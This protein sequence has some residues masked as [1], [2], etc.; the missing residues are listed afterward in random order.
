MAL[1]A[2]MPL[3][4]GKYKPL[5]SNIAYTSIIWK[6][7]IENPLSKFAPFFP[8]KNQPKIC[9]KNP[10]NIRISS[11]GVRDS[12]CAGQETLESSKWTIYAKSSCSSGCLIQLNLN[13]CP[14]GFLPPH[15]IKIDWKMKKI[16]K[17]MVTWL[18]HAN[19]RFK[20]PNFDQICSQ[21]TKN[22]KLLSLNCHT[23][24][25]ED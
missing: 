24:Y 12:V 22:L 10:R 25:L 3:F 21:C 1:V 13:L 9:A 23:W 5:T 6:A 2:Y 15:I 8:R 16:L 17:L 18:S 19:Y 11:V 14:C 4:G 7:R 20:N